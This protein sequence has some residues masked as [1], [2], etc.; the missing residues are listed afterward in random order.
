MD[1]WRGQATGYAGDV[2][3][4]TPNLDRFAS[5]G[6]DFRQAVSAHPL[7]V[8]FRGALL[9]S[10][11]AHST[12][13]AGHYSALPPG[14]VTAAHRL[15][16]VGYRTAYLGKWHLY[17][18]LPDV[19]P[20]VQDVVVPPE[21]RGGFE[22]WEASEGGDLNDPVLHRHD[23]PVPRRYEGYEPDVLVERF[24][25][26]LEAVGD[27]AP[28]FT[29]VSTLP[30]HNP[31]G[32]APAEYRAKY[33]PADIRLRPNVPCVEPLE[34]RVREDLAGYYAHIEATD[35][36]FGRLL[37][38]LDARGLSQDT[39]VVFLSDHGDMLGSHGRH[40]KT[41]PLEES[42]R[43][44]ML[45]RWPGRIEQATSDALICELDVLPTM[46]GLIGHD[47]PEETHGF[48]LSPVLLGEAPG[49]RD[50]VLLQ[51]VDGLA[52][53]PAWRLPWRAVRTTRAMYGCD[54]A[55]ERWLF[56]LE[57][58]P[59]ELENRAS[60]GGAAQFR[61]SM[62]KLLENALRRVD[63]GFALP[64]FHDVPIGHSDGYQVRR[65]PQAAQRK[66]V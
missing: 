59:Y 10:R 46:L 41:V 66:P 53:E 64:E 22:Y 49:V 40:K 32:D 50:H 8:P 63:D 60:D 56:D 36:A 39:V 52:H 58:D 2:N 42:A 28:W 5:E 57:Q 21:H 34:S 19:E 25:V 31:Y 55:A 38:M 23:D 35:A 1:Q 62:R 54:I 61:A 15:S 7:C 12:G 20:V 37:E 27:G 43:I 24:E 26:F 33:D 6:F 51:Q 14:T 29:V 17:D 3:A 16:D 30:P 18:H 44:P 4:C 48:D 45:I 9:T 47:V 13:I 11:H 65:W